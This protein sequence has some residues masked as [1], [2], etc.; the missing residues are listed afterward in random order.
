MTRVPDF[1]REHAAWQEVIALLEREEAALI[2]GDTDALAALTDS[3]LEKLDALSAHGRARVAYFAAHRVEATPA[4]IRAWLA[5]HDDPALAVQWLALED[6]ERRARALN[7]RIGTL[8]DMR[9]A[10]TRQAL[11]VLIGALPDESRLYGPAG[12]P[13]TPA[14]GRSISTV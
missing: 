9:L 7:A 8:I 14:G 1:V 3:K 6:C 4:G 11:N 12:K 10:A 2:A 13:D 5:R